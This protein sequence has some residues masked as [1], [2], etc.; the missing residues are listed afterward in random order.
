GS[1]DVLAFTL[2]NTRQA[3]IGDVIVSTDAAIRNA[4]TYRTNPHYET[5]LYVVHGILHLL[6]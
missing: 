2:A 3:L 4:K 1:T 6:G 5:F